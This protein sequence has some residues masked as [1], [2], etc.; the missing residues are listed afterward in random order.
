MSQTALKSRPQATA[1]EGNT[2][3]ATENELIEENESADVYRFYNTRSGVHFYTSSSEER[4]AI[5]A[6]PD[7]GYSF[8]GIA[9]Q[10]ATSSGTE[11]YRFYNASK[12]YHFLTAN[13]VEADSIITN[14]LGENGWG[15]AY[16]GRSYK[17]A[18]TETAQA[19]TEVY[20]FYQAEKG[21]HFYTS[22]PDEIREVISQSNGAE[23]GDDL[24][25]A[26]HAPLLEGGW[27]YQLEGLAWYV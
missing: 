20:R 14:S 11:L 6:N 7:W 17:V 23:Y 10:A 21:V 12:G 15:Y 24:E 9:Y 27:G 8:E 5:E 4:D 19:S 16:E 26:I 25:A 2:T 18:M 3:L 1:T 22:N 13:A